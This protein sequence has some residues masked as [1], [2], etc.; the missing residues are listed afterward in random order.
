MFVLF[1]VLL[2][3]AGKVQAQEAGEAK[4]YVSLDEFKLELVRGNVTIFT[5]PIGIGTGQPFRYGNKVYKFDTP[6]GVRRVI[7]KEKNPVWRRPGWAYEEFSVYRDFAIVRMQPGEIYYMS[8]STMLKLD[9]NRIVR[10]TYYGESWTWN[11]EVEVLDLVARKIY[12]PPLGVVHRN[13]EGIL[14]TR[15]L[16]LGD[17]Y[18]IHGTDDP[19]SIGQRSS[20]GCIRMHNADVEKLYELVPIGTRVVIR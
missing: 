10:S 8:D 7:A 1:L 13:L 18:L 2:A 19:S 14:G 11:R 5:A 4:I 12:M 3:L 6:V 16:D 17:G 15:K 9:G 20:H